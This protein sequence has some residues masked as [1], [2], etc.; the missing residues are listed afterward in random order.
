[1]KNIF[2]NILDSFMGRGL[3]SS[4][5]ECATHLEP[6]LGIG[7]YVPVYYDGGLDDILSPWST[8][9]KFSP[10]KM[11]CTIDQMVQSIQMGAKS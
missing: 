11:S 9:D 7:H 8:M 10:S 4:T 1:M 6:Y 5:Y 2:S 3:L